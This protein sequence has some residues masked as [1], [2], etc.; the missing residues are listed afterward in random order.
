MIVIAKGF[1][2]LSPLII[3][4]MMVMWESSQWLG[5]N[6]VQSAGKRNSRE[7]WIGALAA[8]V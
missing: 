2:P 7:A 4:S 1:V 3:V 8:E 6:I 5:K